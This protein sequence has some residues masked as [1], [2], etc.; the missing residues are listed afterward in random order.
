[1]QLRNDTPFATMFFESVDEVDRPINV[2]IL[3]GTFD[4]SPG[5]TLEVAD[6]QT[7]VVMADEY[8]D[9]P[10]TS[11]IR[12]DTDLVPKKYHTDI[13]LEA[14]AHAPDTMP[15]QAWEVSV[16]VGTLCK[17]LRVTGP[18]FWNC[19]L[20]A[21]TLSQP[22][23]CRE[24][25]IRYEYAYGGTYRR[26]DQEFRYE[27]NPVGRGFVDLRHRD[28]KDPVPAP[29]IETLDEPIRAIDH[30]YRPAG[31]G[32]I[33]KHCLPRRS[34]CGTPD[35]KWID[36]RWPLRPLDFDFNYYNCASEGLRY[37]G[38]LQGNELVVLTNLT[39]H[40]DLRFQLPSL[41]QL[42]FSVDAAGAFV[43]EPLILDTVHINAIKTQ[44]SLTWRATFLR[45]AP[46]TM[47]QFTPK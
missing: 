32:P 24:V 19:G 46:P 8:Y 16:S 18:R 20:L 6:E 35:A 30:P 29:Q 3:R 43:L 31:F 28:R 39:Q 13:T 47:V 14:V 11:S 44:V 36:E 23:P 34:R 12:V 7:P 45:P 27:L 38:F 42:V 2:A 22:E 21:W 9:Q 15:Q 41:D 10:L 37:E 4:I 1:M 26:D 5:G 33:P 25:P 40:G 17:R